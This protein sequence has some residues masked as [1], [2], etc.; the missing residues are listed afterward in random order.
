MQ[1]VNNFHKLKDEFKTDTGLDANTNLSLYI[2]YYQ[3]RFSDMA[4]QAT[5]H[6]LNRMDTLPDAIGKSLTAYQK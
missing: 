1:I 5:A 4:Y 2:A 6:L 3:G